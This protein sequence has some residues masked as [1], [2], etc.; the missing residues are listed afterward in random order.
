[1][2]RLPTHRRDRAVGPRQGATEAARRGWL[3]PPPSM[4]QCRDAASHAHHR[5]DAR[6][7]VLPAV[8]FP[9]GT[10][11]NQFTVARFKSRPLATLVG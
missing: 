6:A 8:Y 3:P 2:R 7:L 5:T 1:M 4:L 10:K 11:A 9:S